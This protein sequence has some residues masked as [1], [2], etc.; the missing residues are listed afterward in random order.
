[1]L[2]TGAAGKADLVF[3]SL[4]FVVSSLPCYLIIHRGHIGTG[5]GLVAALLV[6]EVAK[7]CLAL[8]RPV[9]AEY[10]AEIT[11]LEI[12][13]GPG[14]SPFCEGTPLGIPRLV[15]DIKGVI[16]PRK[17]FPALKSRPPLCGYPATSFPQWVELWT[18]RGQV[19]VKE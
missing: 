4:V 19:A 5:N 1:M 7:R 2:R 10:D 11:A 13:P 14:S 15:K 18:R 3:L 12:M 8:I 17:E 9:A 6:G 16:S